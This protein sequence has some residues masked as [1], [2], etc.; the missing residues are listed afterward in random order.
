MNNGVKYSNKTETMK[1]EKIKTI[2]LIMKGI[3]TLLVAIVVATIIVFMLG[4]L[5]L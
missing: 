5:F 3:I 1:K 2:E 4:P